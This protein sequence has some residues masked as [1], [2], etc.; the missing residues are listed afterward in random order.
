M[1]APGALV[2]C[3]DAGPSVGGGHVMR[4]LALAEEWALRGGTCTF[5]LPED[6]RSF[7]DAV[8]A[9]GFACELAPSERLVD[10]VRALPIERSTD[11]IVADGY[12]FE[13]GAHRALRELAPVLAVDDG[14]HYPE[15]PVDVVLNPTVAD[16]GLYRDSP[17]R[18]L[19][20][21]RYAPIRREFRFARRRAVAPQASSV[22]VS[23]GAAD[24][25][26]AT[27]AAVKALAALDSLGSQAIT[28][29]LGPGYRHEATLERALHEA[30]LPATLA[31]AP[32]D[33]AALL[34]SADACVV[35]AGSTCW[36]LAVL[37]VPMLAV[38]LA[39]NQRPV[40]EA[41]AAAEGALVYDGASLRADPR[42]LVPWLSRLLAHARARA[43]LVAGAAALVDGEG[44]GRVVAAL[45]D[46]PFRLRPVRPGD[47]EQVFRWGNDPVAR[48]M[49][50]ST[51][52]I[53][54][55]EH[56]AWFA[57]RLADP[58][59]YFFIATDRDDR[60]LGYTRF[61]VDGAAARVSVALD[62]AARGR[63][64]AAPII[65]HGSRLVFALSGVERLD[66]TIRPDNAV[67]IRSF[68]RAGFRAAGPARVGEV[69]AVRYERL[70]V[71]R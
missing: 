7:A 2:V 45:I 12:R 21:R 35:G 22:V 29:V 44:A 67:S 14:R 64:L 47:V 70:R 69:D 56:D 8:I 24:P 43:S 19:T 9:R 16:D 26:D 40:A 33:M 50:F 28:I 52:A 48:T 4:S 5:V 54:R 25:D 31:R 37:G 65:D 17:A 23:M 61:E 13:P 11:W 49:S 41:L 27:S 39:P 20:G 6:G 34:S 55:S 51:R 59:T 62:P 38:V 18:A 32:R 57:A 58:R 53:E 15:Y 3:A 66:A 71:S 30:S 42:G 1:R 60:A 68:E 10:R 63:G 46:A 36:E